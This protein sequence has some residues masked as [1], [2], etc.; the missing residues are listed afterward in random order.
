LLTPYINFR[1]GLLG[2]TTS[3]GDEGYFHSTL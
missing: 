2:T 3:R 1:H